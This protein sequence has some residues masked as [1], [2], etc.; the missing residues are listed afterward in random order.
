MKIYMSVKEDIFTCKSLNHRGNDFH[1]YHCYKALRGRVVH[2]SQ[3]VYKL[4]RK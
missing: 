3:A 4:M 2:Q 1:S